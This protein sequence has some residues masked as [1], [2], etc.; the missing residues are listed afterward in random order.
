MGARSE[1]ATG[2]AKETVGRIMG[3]ANL[4]SEGKADRQAGDVK[5]KVGH[6]KD[7]VEELVDKAADKAEEV[8]D[9]VKNVLH[10]K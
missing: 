7:Q 8:I 9:K 6:A 1:Q 5:E 4:E 10:R 2:H 3:D